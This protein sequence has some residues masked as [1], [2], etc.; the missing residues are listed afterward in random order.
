MLKNKLD[1]VD[2]LN[3][4]NK[5]EAILIAQN[6][7]IEEGLDKGYVIR[8]PSVKD[9]G[10]EWEVVFNA[11]YAESMKKANIFGALGIFKWWIS[12]GVNKGNGAVTSVGGPDL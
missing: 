5:E 2:S 1:S 4:V 12:V 8:K 6:Y 11:T 7:L 3:G 9:Y 10:A